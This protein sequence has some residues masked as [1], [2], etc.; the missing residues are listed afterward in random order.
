MGFL[1]HSS[2]SSIE[3]LRDDPFFRKL[4]PKSTGREYFNLKWAEEKFD[5]LRELDEKD[6]QTTFCELTAMTIISEIEKFS[7]T[8][9]E[10]IVCGG[11]RLNTYLI[12][13]LKELGDKPIRLSEDYEIDG[14]Y[15][16]AAAFAWLAFCNLNNL[17]IDWKQFTG[18]SKS[19]T[20][21][22]I[23]G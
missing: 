19:G 12:T 7:S 11:G 20:L 1:G 18:A 23:F 9:Q 22:V 6:V 16:E 21:G 10:I 13:R 5:G 15:I 17:S 8:T 14:D 2:R 4:P 3:E